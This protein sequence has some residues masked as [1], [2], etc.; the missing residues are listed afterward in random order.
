M[1]EIDN[2]LQENRRFP[3]PDAWTKSANITDP[4]VYDRAAAD[5]EAFWAELRPRARVDAA[6]GPRARVA[7]AEREVVRRRQAQC[8]RQLPRSPCPHRAPQ[9]GRHSSGRASRAIAAR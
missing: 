3:P 4:A 1:S 9:Q 7:A 2:L 8:Q 6:V 5:P